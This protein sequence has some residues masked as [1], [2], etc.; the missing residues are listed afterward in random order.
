M[1]APAASTPAGQQAAG[2]LFASAQ[3]G[4]SPDIITC[5]KGLG[6]GYQPIAAVL[7]SARIVDAI[8]DGSGLLANGHTYMSHAVACAAALAAIDAIRDEDLL[9]AVAQKGEELAAGLNQRFGQHP[10][11]GDIRG[12]G[13]FH[14]LEFVVDRDSKQPLPRALR[15]SET[16]KETALELGLICYPSSGTA[17]GING[18][19]VVLAPPYI[20]TSEQIVE[21]IDKLDAALAACLQRTCISS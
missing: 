21:L 5:A 3:E 4:V 13:L 18:D 12:R 2:S 20:V 10:N 8:R 6:A 19:H 17:D 1:V 16:L 11:V 14:A 7:V 9:S 15:F